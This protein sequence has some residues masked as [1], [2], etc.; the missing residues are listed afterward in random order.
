MNNFRLSSDCAYRA[1]S[2]TPWQ[3][4]SNE[5]MNGAL[6]DYFSKSTGL[7]THTPQRLLAVENELNI[8]PWP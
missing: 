3:R 5:N 4:G 2:T 6:R 8:C 7:S 1:R